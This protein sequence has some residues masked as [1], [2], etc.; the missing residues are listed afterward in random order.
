MS[1]QDPL[2]LF[3][4]WFD[5][6]RAAGL[7][8]PEAMALATATPDGRPSVR[9]VLYRGM[10]EG[11]LRFFTNLGSRKAAELA[12]NPR[13][14]TV[15][16]FGPLGRQVRFEGE[17]QRLT[18]AEDDAYFAARPRGHQLA[19]LASPQSQPIEYPQ[20]LERYAALERQHQGHLVPRPEGWGGYRLRPDAI[21]FWSRK[22]NRLHERI[23]YRRET[24][25]SGPWR[26][27]SV[28]P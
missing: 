4:R 16:H 26:A 8:E 15:F 28:G 1:G 24:G 19:A 10:S 12:A 13:A 21:E 27:T 14:A 22:Q 20:L 9:L 11:G 25:G 6:A 7:E 2:E 18:A 17:V 3:V 5:E 23:V